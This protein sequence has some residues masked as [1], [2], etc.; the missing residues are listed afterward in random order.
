MTD[1]RKT[2]IAMGQLWRKAMHIRQFDKAC[3]NP[4]VAQRKKLQQII[5]S[6]TNTAFG[7]TN[8]FERISSLSDYQK[9]VPPA[10]YEDLKPYIDAVM[11]GQKKQLTEDEP[12]M[13][14][15][16]S[17]T[18]D[19]PKYIPINNRHLV[20]YTHA[21]QIHNYHLVKDF[22]QA[23]SGQFFVISSNDE[24]GQVPSGLP[25]GAVSGLLNRRQSPLIRR[26]FAVPYEVCK[27]KN[28]EMKYYLMLRTALAQNVTAF[29]A[30]N[31]SSLILL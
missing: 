30:C 14:A 8:K 24:E 15:T 7:R 10:S 5:N 4:G 11:A 21:F 31:P 17:G 22:W 19:R 18:T 29:L 26:H 23:T 12:F 13:F 3:A 1:W 9:F 6:N 20:D 16:T 2:D 28:V 25:Y 27:I